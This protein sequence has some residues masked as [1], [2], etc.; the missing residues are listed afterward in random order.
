ML[1]A[2][3]QPEQSKIEINKIDSMR[4]KHVW[5]SSDKPRI[6]TLRRSDF[7]ISE[8]YIARA[9]STT[10]VIL[11]DSIGHIVA[12]RQTR[13]GINVFVAEY[14]PNG[15]LKGK[16]TLTDSGIDTGPATYYYEDGRVRSEGELRDGSRVGTWKD[17]D[18]EGFPAK[19]DNK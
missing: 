14:Y 15:Q 13:K 2:C 11:K 18:R 10:T 12:M 19:P 9:D 16:V 8:N 4:L 5:E 6:D 7:Y 3:G 17:Y 1:T